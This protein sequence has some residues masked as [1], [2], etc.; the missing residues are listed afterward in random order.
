MK[1]KYKEIFKLMRMLERSNISFDFSD[2]SVSEYDL[3]FILPDGAFELYQISYPSKHDQKISVIEGFGTVG[4]S[5]DRLEIMGGL[6]PYER[7]E[8]GDEVLGGLTA[9]NVFKRIKNDYYGGK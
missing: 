1:T 6:T 5:A 3:S 7:Y 2:R 8:Y 9:Y 4:E